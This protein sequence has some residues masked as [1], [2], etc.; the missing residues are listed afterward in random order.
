MSVSEHAHIQSPGTSS[1]KWNAAGINVRNS[2]CALTSQNVC[3]EKGLHSHVSFIYTAH[4]QKVHLPQVVYEENC[5]NF[6]KTKK[7]LNGENLIKI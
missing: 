5:Q 2:T 7:D 1:P 4:N 3:R 6:T